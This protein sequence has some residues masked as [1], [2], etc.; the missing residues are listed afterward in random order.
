MSQSGIS[1]IG[2]IQEGKQVPISH[3][4]LITA[5]KILIDLTEE[6]TMGPAKDQLSTLPSCPK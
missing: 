3:L 1:D 4:E 6:I 5:G 2:T